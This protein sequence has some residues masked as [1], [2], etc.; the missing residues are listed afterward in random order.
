M[1]SKEMAV[2]APLVAL[3]YDRLFLAGSWRVLW[4]RRGAV[5]AGLAAGWLVLAACIAS[6]DRGA[7][8]GLHFA[9]VTPRAYLLASFAVVTHYV[10]LAFWPHPL[11]ID[12]A[13]PVT[14]AIAP[15][16]PQIAFL[17]A[18]AAA[19]LAACRR[20]PR[21]AFPALVF[22][23]VLAPTSSVVPLAGAVAAEHR[24]YLPL[25][26][27]VLLV[28][29]G[30]DALARR[31]GPRWRPVAAV[32]G[33]AAVLVLGGAT[34]RRNRDFADAETLWSRTVAVRPD[35]ARAHGNLGTAQLRAGRLEAAVASY[36][37]MAQLDPQNPAAHANWGAALVRLG[38]LDEAHER[39]RRARAL[40]PLDAQVRY[41][42]GLLHR[43]RGDLRAAAAEWD[44]VL[45]I[46]PGRRAARHDLALALLHL[47]DT[48]AAQ[49]HL[50]L[51]LQQAPDDVAALNNLGWTLATAPEDG[52]RS[53]SEAL[54]CAER[55]A[56]LVQRDDPEILDTLAA[57]LA[58]SGRFAEAALAAAKAGAL[59][60]STGR[61]DLAAQ[62]AGRER[63][64][65][66]GRPYRAGRT[67][68][69]SP[70]RL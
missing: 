28:V 39:L 60:A 32:V 26:C 5:H 44:S 69:P 38:R 58:E 45:I 27:I 21:P 12:Y 14:G 57:A 70:R 52:L 15:V 66:A 33:A 13:W 20:T 43:A 1:G 59:A 7:S 11:V 18:L 35:N 34:W 8:V 36:A 40:A 55:A 48:A 53:G 10:R 4:R 56:R 54:R 29:L 65:R 6:G 68:A 19:T 2:S 41:D 3:L 46:D 30:V 51:Y 42:F 64:Y 24:M 25:A 67:P 63:L 31:A 50:R 37:R 23:A 16:L 9:D 61:A 17:L 62:L 47:G 22:F 49:H